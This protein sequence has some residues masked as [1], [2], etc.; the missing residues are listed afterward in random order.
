MNLVVECLNSLGGSEKVF[1]QIQQLLV[2][3]EVDL[4]LVV[5]LVYHSVMLDFLEVF[6]LGEEF[7]FLAV[8]GFGEVLCRHCY[9]QLLL[10]V[11]DGDGLDAHSVDVE[12][13][14]RV[15]PGYG[16]R[17]D[18]AI[19]DGLMGDN[20]S[21]QSCTVIITFVFLREDQMIITF[22]QNRNFA[23][24]GSDRIPCAHPPF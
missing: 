21:P 20:A 11:M 9:K 6:F 24:V 5:D 8:G 22:Q 1:P 23:R 18:G 15:H 2:V 13:V 14:L 12:L 3:Q 17:V 4:D 19:D 7:E 16:L 10:D